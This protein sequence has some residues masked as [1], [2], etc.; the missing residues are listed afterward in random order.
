MPDKM[1]QLAD[2]CRDCGCDVQIDCMMSGYTTF[3]TGGKTPL[4]IEPHNLEQLEQACKA[5][6][7]LQVPCMVIGNGSNLLV[8]DEGIDCAVLVLNSQFAQIE[9]VSQTEIFCTAGVTLAQLC[10]FACEAGLTGLE[11]AYG[12]PG[13]V[14]GAVYMNAGAYGGEM[15]DVV[16]SVTYF[17][18]N[19]ELCNRSCDMLDYSYRHSVFM[20]HPWCITGVTFALREGKKEEIRATMQDFLQRRREK[21]PLEYPS[22]GSTFKRPQGAFA[23]QLIDTCGL[24]GYRVGGAMVSEKHAGFVINYDSATS[25][26]ILN[27]ISQVK[28]TVKEKTGF[29][30][31]CEVKII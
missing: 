15:K 29:Q 14:G 1:R 28:K 26:D 7:T 24:K 9:R 19:I 23:S 2:A 13:T 5:A 10:N 25:A 20:L 27:L 3:R 21:Q 16:R 17:D 18:E 6:V 4:L 30:L 12:I 31:E 8:R 11:F 22:A